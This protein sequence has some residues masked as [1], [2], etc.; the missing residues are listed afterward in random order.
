MESAYYKLI[1][2]LHF[3]RLISNLAFALLALLSTCHRPDSALQSQEETMAL[4]SLHIEFN[5]KLIL[6]H[7]LIPFE[8]G[9]QWD[10]HFESPLTLVSPNPPFL[11]FLVTVDNS[12]YSMRAMLWYQWCFITEFFWIQSALFLPINRFQIFLQSFLSAE[13]KIIIDI[14]ILV[15]VSR[16]R[17]YWSFQVIFLLQLLF[18]ISLWVNRPLVVSPA[19]RKPSAFQHLETQW[20]IR[21]HALLEA[22]VWM[23]LP[24]NLAHNRSS[25]NLCECWIASKSR[26]GCSILELLLLM[27]DLKRMKIEWEKSP[28]FVIEY[29]TKLKGFYLEMLL[30]LKYFK[31]SWAPF[32]HLDRWDQVK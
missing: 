3:L 27:I 24:R 11:L 30:F 5:R 7:F 15:S 23:D 1:I 31:C 26:Q 6:A 18:L 22:R 12:I 25:H 21:V 17:A 19:F 13:W 20:I 14:Y 10:Y 8:L 32:W 16:N 4:H 29:P 28:D 2:P 9:F